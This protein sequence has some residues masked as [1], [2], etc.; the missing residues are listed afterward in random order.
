MGFRGGK[1]EVFF[2]F[3]S[4]FGA[5]LLGFSFVFFMFFFR[6]LKLRE[7]RISFY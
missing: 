1:M 3:V 6:R 2:E 7:I 4:S 5:L